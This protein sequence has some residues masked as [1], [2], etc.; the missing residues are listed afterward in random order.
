MQQVRR[1]ASSREFT[2]VDEIGRTSDSLFGLDLAGDP[3][4]LLRVNTAWSRAVGSHLRTV[5]RPSSFVSGRLAVEVADQTWKKELDH[6]TPSILARLAQVMPSEPVAEVTFRVR[7][8]SASS[9][10]MP[11]R[12]ALAPV[13][14]AEDARRESWSSAEMNEPLKG[15][16]D[17]ELRCRLSRVMGRYLAK[18]SRA[19]SL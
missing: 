3:M 19:E 13:P 18:A 10:P 11:G 15:V 4:R 16:R 6:L 17:G 2:S 12:V 5:S 7:R 14:A 8:A 9:A 1:R